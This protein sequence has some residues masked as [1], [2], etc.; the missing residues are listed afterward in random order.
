MEADKPVKIKHLVFS[1]GSIWGFAAAG[2]L[3]EA[4]KENFI[5][6]NDIESIYGTSI[7]AFMGL[8]F[9]LKID[10]EMI[11]EY[12]INRPIQNLI[13]KYVANVL[14][15]FQ[16]KGF[17]K[18]N[19]FVDFFSSLFHSVDLPLETTMKELYDYNQIDFHIYVTELNSFQLVDISHRTHPTMHVL[20]AVYASCSIPVLFSPII[21][22]SKCYIDGCFFLNFP[23]EKCLA[24]V[25]NPGEIFAIT[26]GQKVINTESQVSDESSIFDLL[27]IL[28]DRLFRRVIIEGP[29]SQSS[30]PFIIH[31]FEKNTSLEYYLSVLYNKS[32]REHLIQNGKLCF[33]NHHKIWESG[34]SGESGESEESNKKT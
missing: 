2:I 6:M 9:S 32:E 12:V 8:V 7:G 28:F 25:E 27:N 34:E 11:I 19:I 15:L 18:K 30:P 5:D 3:Y 13:E 4:L 1:G 16:T 14:E 23:I 21:H 31:Y 26:L 17:F 20:D 10:K 33:Q 22:E 24:N 29:C